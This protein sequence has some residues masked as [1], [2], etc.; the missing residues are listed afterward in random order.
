MYVFRYVLLVIIYTKYEL[1]PT[2]SFQNQQIEAVGGPGEFK[3]LIKSGF[4][5]LPPYS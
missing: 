2:H 3:L 4:R 1:V 5:T